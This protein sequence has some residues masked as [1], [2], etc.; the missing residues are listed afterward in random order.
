MSIAKAVPLIAGAAGGLVVSSTGGS[1]PIKDLM[2]GNTEA[3]V[4]SLVA[5][6][7]F[8]S[9]G[10]NKFDLGQGKGIKILAGGILTS[11]LIGWIAE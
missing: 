3:L 9:M 5:N 6:Y 4:D 2:N 11:K 1:S 10:G 8:Y 7:T